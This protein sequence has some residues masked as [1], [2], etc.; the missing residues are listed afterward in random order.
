MDD[1]DIDE[2]EIDELLDKHITQMD[3]ID[4]NLEE[5]LDSMAFLWSVTNEKLQEDGVCFSCKKQIDFEN[6]KA[7]I[8]LAKNTEP[9]VVA[10]VLLC[11]DCLKKLEEQTNEVEE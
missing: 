3:S 6:E 1:F 10:F 9:G 11:D 4:S 7:H 2:K 5:H 8:R